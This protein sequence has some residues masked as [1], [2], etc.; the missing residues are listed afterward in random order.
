MRH[1]IISLAT[2]L[3]VLTTHGVASSQDYEVSASYEPNYFSQF[4]PNTAQDMVIRIPGFTLQDDDGG[5]RGFGQASLNILINGRR[6]SSK[7]S[8]A[9]EILGRITADKVT[10]I[11]I[12]DGAS[13]GIPGLSGQVANIISSTGKLSGSWNYAARFEEGTEPQLTEGDISINGSN[14][15][16]NIEYAASLNH[17]I[18]TF[19]EVGDEQFFDPDDILFEDRREDTEFELTRPSL[20]VNLTFTQANGNIANLNLSGGVENRNFLAVEDFVAV[21]PSGQTGQSLFRSGEDEYEYEIGGDYSF[22]VGNGSLKLIGLHSFEK[23]DFNTNFDINVFGEA[24]SRQDFNTFDEE[25]EIIGRAEYSWK[26]A[27][28]HDWQLSWEGA[29]NYLDSTT[30]FF[31]DDEIFDPENVRVE[32]TRT[33]ANL[34]HSRKV[35]DKLNLQASIGAEFSQIEVTT[36]TDPGSD[37]FRPKGFLALSY[38]ANSRYTWRTKIE[39]AVGQLDFTDFRVSRSLTDGTA[40]TG[41]VDIVPTQ[42]WNAEIE[43]ERKDSKVLSGTLTF[44]ANFIEDPIDRILFPDGSEGPGNLD[45]AWLYGVNANATWLLD[46]YGLKGMRI[47]GSGSLQDSSIEDPVT[48][49]NRRLNQTDLWSYSLNLRHDIPQTS[50]AWGVDLEQEHQS[51]FFRRDEIRDINFDQPFINYFITHKNVLGMTASLRLQNTPNTTLNRERFI[52]D[53]DRNG[54]LLRREFVA[55]ER[56]NRISLEIS[57]TF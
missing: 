30:E 5:E 35:S 27:A 8:G 18:F 56:G 25:R 49:T 3:T 50:W 47:E 21:T 12:L 39:R 40:N 34:T 45:N 22:P 31:L 11:D 53:G 16:G 52:F 4:Q 13:L 33:E 28:A 14:T 1:H 43:V 15:A 46:S 10:R 6:P 32:E 48:L 42:S 20:D 2:A 44:F 41:N 7:S 55:R 24:P 23:S 54:N 26:S 36:N 9:D 57:D 37:F 38:D 17:G 29:F 19:S 51:P